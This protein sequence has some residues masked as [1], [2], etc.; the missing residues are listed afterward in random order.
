L[1]L[2]GQ[3]AY[4]PDVRAGRLV[5]ADPYLSRVLYGSAR[6]QT[7]AVAR[8]NAADQNV[9]AANR[10]AW[11]IARDAYDRPETTYIF[12][13]G[14]KK[15]GNEIKDWRRI[16]AGTRVILGDQVDNPREGLLRI[17]RDGQ[18]ASD[19]AGQEYNRRTTVYFLPDGRVRRGDEMSENDFRSLSDGSGILVGY[20][21]GGYVSA[22]RS[23][24]DICGGRWSFPSTYYRFPDGRLVSGDRVNE[25]GIPKA[26]MVF[27]RK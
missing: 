16:P 27:Y 18:T 7:R 17:G 13:D 4:D 15:R 9:I 20:V 8:F 12:P 2:H 14:R 21:S 22:K 5:D 10:S 26:T 24:F 23:A 6:E 3:P 25:N 1:G 19:I 11:D